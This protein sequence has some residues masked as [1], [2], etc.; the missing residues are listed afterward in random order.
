[1]MPV[2][3]VFFTEGEL[4]PL[5]DTILNTVNNV[6]K[7]H[8]NVNYCNNH[9]WKDVTYIN[10]NINRRNRGTQFGSCRNG[11][12]YFQLKEPITFLIEA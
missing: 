2:F 10:K 8:T 7:I 5:T 4:Y 6:K 12:P 11:S 1:M 9:C 3:S